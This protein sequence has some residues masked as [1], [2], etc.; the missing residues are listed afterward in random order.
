MKTDPPYCNRVWLQGKIV[1]TPSIQPISQKTQ[2]T[3]FQ[4]VMIESWKNAAGE[5]R[6]RNNT[7]SVEVVGKDSAKVA[8]EAKLGSWATIEGYI[9]SE[10]AK[11]RDIKKVR[12]LT[13]QIWEKNDEEGNN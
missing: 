6:E 4:L 11:G 9:R 10:Q 5:H 1:S 3:S 12:T 8:R 13:I 7:I 2:A